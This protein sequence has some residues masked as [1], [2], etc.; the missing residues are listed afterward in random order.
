MFEEMKCIELS[1]ISYPIKCDMVVLE[2][3]QD[4]FGSIDD[5]E[6]GILDWEFEY[7]ENGKKIVEKRGEN[8]ETVEYFK[9][10][11]KFPKAKNINA[12]LFFMA[13]EG[14]EIARKKPPFK[15]IKE[16][17]RVIDMPL[18]QISRRLHEEFMRCFREK[19][20]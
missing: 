16:A 17:A 7:D 5:F 2:Q 20:E 8:G 19:N 13:N 11:F 6:K 4:M 10:K 12:A 15:S 14:S 9:T 18:S 3:I 1:G